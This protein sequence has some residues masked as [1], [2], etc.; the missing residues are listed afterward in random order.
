[1]KKRICLVMVLVLAAALLCS[2]SGNSSEEKRYDVVTNAQ[3]AAVTQNVLGTVDEAPV[4]SGGVVTA[5]PMLIE[6]EDEEDDYDTVTPAPT[7]RSEYAGATP[8]VIDPIDKPTPTPLPP[9]NIEYVTYDATN[10]HISFEGPTG[11]AID[12]SASDTYIIY[13]TNDDIDYTAFLQIKVVAL[14]SDYTKDQLKTEVTTVMSSMR[15][16][17]YSFSSTKTADRTLLDKTGVYADYSAVL[18]DGT[19]IRGRVH[20]ASANRKLYI[21]HMSCPEGY[22]STYKDKVYARFRSTIKITQ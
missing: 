9:L 12:D 4:I 14:S 17:Y 5:A 15:G 7:I 3:V 18:S 11:W 20:C 10:I 13:D 1:M 19:A 2:C 8:V 6:Q 21:V 22:Y 16:D